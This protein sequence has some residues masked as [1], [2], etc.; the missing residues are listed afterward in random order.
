M[1]SPEES[2][3]C[4]IA[5]S[6]PKCPYV[7]QINLNTNSMLNVDKALTAL[8]GNDYTGLNSGVIHKILSKLDKLE[9]SQQVQRSWV[10]NWK[11]L[12]YTAASVLVTAAITWLLTTRF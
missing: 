2:Q 1:S 8:L 6:N 4:E 3:E 12:F 7:T 11:P 9:N 10:N 5:Y